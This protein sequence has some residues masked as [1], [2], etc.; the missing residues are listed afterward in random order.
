MSWLTTLDAKSHHWPAAARWPYRALK[1]S[2]LLVGIYLALGLAYIERH[3]H[4]FG[5]GTGICVM[6]LLA[7]IKAAVLILQQWRQHRRGPT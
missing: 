6:L 3:E 5:L 1:W 7:L 4:R 2:L